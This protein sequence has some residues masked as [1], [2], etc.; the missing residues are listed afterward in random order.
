MTHHSDGNCPACLE[1]LT[2]ETSVTSGDED[3]M[4]RGDCGKLV[5][6]A[7]N[8]EHM[9]GENDAVD[10]DG[11]EVCTKCAG[12][13]LRS[14]VLRF[15]VLMEAKLRANDHKPGWKHDA[16][17]GLVARVEGEAT[18]LREIVET[19]WENTRRDFVESM[20]PSRG[21]RGAPDLSE[22]IGNEAADVANMAMMVADVCGGLKR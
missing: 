21:W 9:V 10:I 4:P 8:D 20:D 3:W 11:D 18:E 12:S 7:W 6:C 15:A 16:A 13:Y 19:H 14:E 2:R 5:K 17:L 22:A 1:P